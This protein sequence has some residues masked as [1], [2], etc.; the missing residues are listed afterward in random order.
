[1]EDTKSL[2]D[3]RPM[4][5]VMKDYFTIVFYLCEGNKSEVSRRLKLS[6]RTV[7][8]YCKDFD[9]KLDSTTKEIYNNKKDEVVY[10]SITSDQR[11]KWYNRNCF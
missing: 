4:R 1:M 7:R 8:Q 6:V 5:D 11:D 3:I 10:K 9:L 2:E